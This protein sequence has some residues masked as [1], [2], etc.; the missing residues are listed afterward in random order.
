[1][2]VIRQFA[3]TCAAAFL[4]VAAVGAGRCDCFAVSPS[5]LAAGSWVA[6]SSPNASKFMTE[7]KTTFLRLAS[8]SETVGATLDQAV[9]MRP[10]WARVIV[11]G[12]IRVTPGGARGVAGSAGVRILW[13]G[14]SKFTPP[15]PVVVGPA[16]LPADWTQVNQLLDIPAGA[17]D[18]VVEPF[19]ASGASV[20]FRDLN[21]VAWVPTMI[22]EF[23]GNAPAPVRWTATDSDTFVFS[24]G[25]Q[26]FAP[27]HATV[28]GGVLTLHADK[29]RH[30]NYEYQSGE[31]TTLDK[32]QQLYGFFEFRM[33]VPLCMGVWPAAYL[34]KWDNGWPPEIDVQEMSGTNTQIVIE[35]NHYADDYGRH[36]GSSV[37]FDG[38]GIDRSQWH[39]Y[40]V[41][42]EPNA[43]AW[44]VDGKYMGTTGPPGPRVSDVP[45]YIRLNLAVGSYGGDPAKGTWPQDLQC[46][47]VHVYQ[48]WDLPLPLYEGPSQEITLPRDTVVLHA[49]SCS[50]VAGEAVN[51]SLVEGP[52]AVRIDSPHSL[53]TRAT[54]TR[55][56]MYR[57]KVSVA[58]GQ[59]V[60]SR[61]A[62]VFVNPGLARP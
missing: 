23:D 24:P 54:M 21:V 43:L 37:N 45:M 6:Q 32:F 11:R 27:D 61:E 40:A 30:G 56:G 36:Q 13:R 51:W 34:I 25:I 52:G 10:E 35:T 55:P 3:P 42:W 2:Q 8:P 1:M 28:S 7:D 18:L 50:P 60:A 26:H 4:I 44:Y 17:I 62:L 59:S 19:A 39:T 22:D 38:S 15:S 49:I 57:F 58:K 41:A 31:V 48:R 20:D 16:D 47:Y 53:D 46:D 5:L 12:L 14:G 33:R 29:T 9:R